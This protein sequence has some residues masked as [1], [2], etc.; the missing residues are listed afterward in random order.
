MRIALSAVRAHLE[1]ASNDDIDILL[2]AVKDTSDDTL[3]EW[4]YWA[5][6]MT[7]AIDQ[8][9]PTLS[10]VIKESAIDTSDKLLPLLTI[11]GYSCGGRKAILN[12]LAT[13]PEDTLLLPLLQAIHTGFPNT[14]AEWPAILDIIEPL[15][16][17]D[18]QSPQVLDLAAAVAS[19]GTLD[20]PFRSMYL[21][22]ALKSKQLARFRRVSL[23][24][25][26]NN[27]AVHY[28]PELLEVFQSPDVERRKYA[29]AF[30]TIAPF[31]VAESDEH[32]FVQLMTIVLADVEPRVR[33]LGIK[34]LLRRQETGHSLIPFCGAIVEFLKVETDT[35]VWGGAWHR[36]LTI[37]GTDAADPVPRATNGD[38]DW[39][40]LDAD[41]MRLHR[42]EV[43]AAAELHW[44]R[45]QVQSS[46]NQSNNSV[47][48]Q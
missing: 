6:S 24:F 42:A 40:A 9:A 8:N 18:T 20:R 3:R 44:S 14:V 45:L 36:Y 31:E 21:R 46:T 2:A 48:S 5:L 13:K 41:W 37:V 39:N 26:G 23:F 38:E 47:Y 32:R 22:A 27:D 4:Y 1:T 17:D 29:A 35:A 10:Q 15:A 7:D 30:L 25:A 28:L 43:I 11:C 19:R 33:Q 34:S 16:C 12:L